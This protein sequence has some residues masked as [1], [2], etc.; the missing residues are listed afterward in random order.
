MPDELVALPDSIPTLPEEAQR[1]GD[2]DPGD[3][4]TVTVY[5]RRDPAAARL[6]DPSNEARKAPARRRYLT[7]SEVEASF[8]AASADLEAV[9]AYAE[10]LG[11]RTSTASKAKRSVRVTGPLG[12]LADAFGVTLARFQHGEVTFRGQQGALK[13]PASLSGIIEAVLGFDNRPVGRSYL[14]R[15]VPGRTAPPDS[16]SIARQLP[17]DNYY[18]PQVGSLYG[19][20]AAYNGRG[21][22][23]AVFVFNGT[24]GSGSSALGGYEP[25]LLDQYFSQVLGMAAPTITDVVVAGPGN[26]PGNG[27]TPTH[28][29]TEVYLDLCMVG[30]L[31]PGA[32]IAVYFTTFTEQGWVDAISQAATDAQVDPSVLSISY[33][34]PESGSGTAWSAMAV[35][36][37]NQA[38]EAASSAGRTVCCAAGDSGA[39]DEPGTALHVDFPASSPWVLGCGGT[40]LTSGAG[41]ITSEVVWNDL[42]SGNG[43]TGGGVSVVFPRPTWQSGIRPDPLPGLQ[44]PSSGRGVPDVAS[45]AD[46]QTPYVIMGPGGTLEQV[47]GTSAA[48]P[49]WAALASRLNQALGARVGFVNP[50]LYGK[51]HGALRDITEGNNGG[52]D[53]TVGWDACTGWGCPGASTLLAAFQQLLA[54][55][56]AGSAKA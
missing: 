47:G 12:T 16:L 35:K 6:V 38:F 10:S 23:V 34:N 27:T 1:V 37:V 41:T 9:V 24:I 31:A 8:G 18:P 46:P 22:T 29:S 20:P 45:L 17:P 52:Y 55:S 40:R 7:R 13:V 21:E 19:F 54:P 32:K 51:L 33:G 36:Q 39:T 25:A 42:A 56:A 26:V 15:S 3:E 44:A 5:V 4:L 14:R 49:L 53:A 2:V 48:A 11:L 50:L 28:V 43:A 30:S